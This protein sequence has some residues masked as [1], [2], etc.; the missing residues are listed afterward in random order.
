MLP[1]LEFPSVVT[2]YADHFDSLFHNSQQQQH[3]REYVSGLILAEQATIDAMNSLFVERNDQSALNKF[4]TQAVWNEEELNRRRVQL[5]VQSLQR[6]KLTAPRGYLIID[7]TLTHHVGQHIQLIAKLWDHAEQRYTWAH[8]FPVNFRLWS[9]FQEKEER[10][11]LLTW[12][13]ALGSAPTRAYVQAYLLALIRFQARQRAYHTKQ[14][15]GQELVR[16]AAAQALPFATVLFD[17]WYLHLGLIEAIEQ[18]HKDWIGGLPKDRLVDW[19]GRW[20]QV[21]AYLKTI[22]SEAYRRYEI[23]GTPYWVFTKALEVK[24]LKRRVRIIASYDNADLRGEPKLR[25]TNRKDW[26]PTKI[27]TSFL[28]RW[29]TETFNED[30]K[31]HLGLEDYQLR[32]IVGIKRHWYLV[33]LAYSLL[34][35]DA[36]QSRLLKVVTAGLETTGQRCR[37]TA[38]EMVR[39]LVLWAYKQAIGEKS[40]A[41]ILQALGA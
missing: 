3:F 38:Q 40:A 35:L 2:R 15:L 10:Q 7:D 18:C 25:V 36:E 19:Q 4:V 23:Q 8:R 30:A 9:Q 27:L 17:G 21:Q 22:P 41:Q 14:E 24:S 13:T 31:Q 32:K 11:S 26:E 20:V 6:D 33:F 29:P 34:R 5:E 1:I 16:D 37:A 39:T 28:Y 12:R